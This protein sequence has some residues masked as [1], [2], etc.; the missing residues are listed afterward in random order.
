[1][2]HMVARA[3]SGPT[4]QFRRVLSSSGRRVRV[5]LMQSN[6]T[7]RYVCLRD[8]YNLGTTSIRVITRRA[9]G[10]PKRVRHLLRAG[11]A[12]GPL[13][14]LKPAIARILLK[15]EADGGGGG[16]RWLGTCIWR[17]AWILWGCRPR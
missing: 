15:D 14:R 3:R 2:S 16:W 13:G 6:K 8:Y 17:C 11:T 7:P 12:L 5:G 4:A 9:R 10:L 1:M